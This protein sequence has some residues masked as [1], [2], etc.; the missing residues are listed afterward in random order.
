MAETQGFVFVAR[1]PADR[2]RGGEGGPL[3]PEQVSCL[4][5]PSQA[6]EFTWAFHVS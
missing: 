4:P 5:M 2:N 3:Q 6:V 1:E